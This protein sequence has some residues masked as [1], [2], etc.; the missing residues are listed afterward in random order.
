MKGTA[1]YIKNIDVVRLY[2]NVFNNNGPVYVFNEA[3]Y[4]PYYALYSGGR[5]ITYYNE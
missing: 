5:G 3:T 1:L 2:N 4:S